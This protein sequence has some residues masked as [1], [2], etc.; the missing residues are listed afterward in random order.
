LAEIPN[1]NPV[2]AETSDEK[3]GTFASLRI[4]NFRFLLT[5]HM[6]S[7][8][9]Q[10]IQQLTV[11]WLVYSLTGSGTMMG[12]INMVGAVSSVGMIPVGGLLIDRLNHRKLMVFIN[13]WMLVLCL[14]LALLLV[15]G[16]NS[17]FYLFIFAFL[18]GLT[19]TIFTNLRQVAVFDLV[20]RSVTPNAVPLLVTGGGVMR[21]IGPAIGGFLILWF[22]PAGNYFLQAGAYALIAVTIFQLRFPPREP[23]AVKTSFMKNI[24]EGLRYVGKKRVTRTFMLMGFI[25]PALTVPI[26]TILPT[27]YVVKIFH[28]GPEILGVLLAPFGVGSFLGALFTA[29]LSRFER[30]GLIQ[31]CALFLLSVSLIVFAF[32][33]TLWAA[34]PI[35]LCAGFFEAIFITTNQTLL[36]L[37]IPDELRGRVIS[38]VN[39]SGTLSFVGGMVAGV[40]AD[41]FGTPKTI[42]I[43]LA[44][45]A[46]VTA[47]LVFIFSP[48]IRNYRLSSGINSGPR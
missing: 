7:V 9:A 2:A 31:L 35:L 46:A 42:T 22:G 39:L 23:T 18:A 36:Q 43:I 12:T 30:R 48:I 6:L 34:M 27:I 10:W 26:V 17:I 47:I 21:S 40:G 1:P 45:A 16:H 41:Y 37:S 3:V 8:A 38:L 32:T 24:L 20:P 19:Q 14:G 29:S 33:T 5:V 28:A 25:T 4:R 11:N 13:M 15:T 44:G